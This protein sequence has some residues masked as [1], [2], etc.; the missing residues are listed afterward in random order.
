MEFWWGLA[1][2]IAWD[3]QAVSNIRS[4]PSKWRPFVKPLCWREKPVRSIFP[5]SVVLSM[6]M[7][8]S[9]PSMPFNL[10][11]ECLKISLKI[12]TD[13]CLPLDFHFSWLSFLFTCPKFYI[14]HVIELLSRFLFLWIIFFLHMLPSGGSLIWL[15]SIFKMSSLSLRCLLPGPRL[16]T[17]CW[18]PGAA[19]LDQPM[20]CDPFQGSKNW[21][22]GVV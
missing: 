21:F 16:Q 5:A 13:K 12:S 8:I 6:S 7:R 17:I 14:W 20:G 1:L 3:R 15:A 18:Y 22:T 11:S 2:Q 19:V 9:I 10:T 4:Q